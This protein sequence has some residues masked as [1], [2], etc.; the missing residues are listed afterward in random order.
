MKKI[1]FIFGIRPKG[2]KM[3]D[4]ITILVATNEFKTI[5]Y[6]EEK[7]VLNFSQYLKSE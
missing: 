4:I 7:I 5:N 1:L 2:I 3:A 6:C